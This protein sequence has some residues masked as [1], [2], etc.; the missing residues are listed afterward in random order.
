MILENREYSTFSSTEQGEESKTIL[1]SNSHRVRKSFQ[2]ESG[3]ETILHGLE[4]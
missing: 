4:R 1:K 3:Q 2:R